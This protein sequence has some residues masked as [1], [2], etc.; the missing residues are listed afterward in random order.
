MDPAAKGFTEDKRVA[1]I[2]SEESCP[3]CESVHLHK[4]DNLWNCK[5]CG[6]RFADRGGL[7]YRS[8]ADPLTLYEGRGIITLKERRA[9][10]K[11]YRLWYYGCNR[12]PYVLMRYGEVRG[13]SDADAVMLLSTEYYAAIQSIRGEEQRKIAYDVCCIGNK[14]GRG[15]ILPLR[16]ALQDLMDHFKKTASKQNESRSYHDTETAASCPDAP[17]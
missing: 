6:H 4:A 14:A 2:K 16:E 7:E 13:G 15:G 3:R 11:L 9:G 5:E 17:K 8:F 12:S 10:E 1:R